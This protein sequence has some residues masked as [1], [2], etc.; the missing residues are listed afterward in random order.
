M[1]ASQSQAVS[2]ATAVGSPQPATGPLGYVGIDVS[3]DSLVVCLLPARQSRNFPQTTAG[4][5]AAIAWLQNLPIGRIVLEATGGYERPLMIALLDAQLPV[6]VVNPRQSHHAAR[7][8]DKLDKSDRSDAE[9]LAW[10]AEHVQSALTPRPREKQLAL[11]DLVARRGQ[12]VQLKTME[13][14]RRQQAHHATARASIDEVL[15]LLKRE[16]ARLERAIAKLIQADDQWRR[17]AQLLQSASGVGPATSHLLV[18]ELPELGRA[19]RAQIGALAGVA[20]RL[21]QS[22][23]HDGRRYIQGGR[24]SVRTALYM[25]T[26]SAIRHNPAIKKYYIHLRQLGKVPKVAITACMRKL[27]IVLNSM[28]KTDTA[29]RDVTV[30]L[31]QP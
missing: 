31:L 17:Q 21:D 1:T 10:M 24:A 25:A 14:N 4:H 30:P 26:L 8:L 6:S 15:R 16:I 28:L 7:T 27:L 11:Q 19:N 2:Q 29:W 23:K 22:G 13:T 5:V 3:K 12:L 9:V 18:A 20:P